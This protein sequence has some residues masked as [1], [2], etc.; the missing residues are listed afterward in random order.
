MVGLLLVEVGLRIALRGGAILA[1]VVPEQPVQAGQWVDH[2]FLPFA[3]RPGAEYDV[4]GVDRGRHVV[5]RV[6]NNSYGFRAHEFPSARRPGDYIVVCLGASTTWGAIAESNAETWPE[7]LERKLQAEYPHRRIRVFNLA[8]QNATVAYSAVV[9]ALV[10]AHLEPDLFVVYH[11]FNDF[12]P[13][14]APEYRVDHAHHFKDLDIDG[15]WPGLQRS[16]PR[17]LLSSYALTLVTWRIDERWAPNSLSHFAQRE[18]GVDDVLLDSH[19]ATVAALERNWRHLETVHAI[20]D[21]MGAQALFA[22]FQYFDGDARNSVQ[23][24]ESLRRVFARRDLDHVDLDALIADNDRALQIDECHF[25]AE[26][27]ELVAAGFFDH[28]VEHG[29]V[30]RDAT[31]GSPRER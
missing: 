29:H 1:Y 6:E 13:V 11:G 25:T 5:A 9:A 30:E 22:T 28:I 16:L 18:I 10:A 24:N 21:G 15:M 3:G 12:G 2:P 19:E 17:W 4:D 20:A 31:P 7:I 8:T 14:V 26:G 27:R 23:V